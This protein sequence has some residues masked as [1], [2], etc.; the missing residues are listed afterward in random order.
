MPETH[1]EIRDLREATSRSIVGQLKT[2]ALE[3]KKLSARSAQ[4]YETLIETPELQTLEAQ[5]QEAKKHANMLQV[6]IKALTL[7]ERMKRFEKQRTS[8]QHVH[9]L[10]SKV[11]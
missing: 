5:I 3:Y 6:Q 8:Q 11:M 1:Q 9:A 10:Q 2:F 7:V 4:T